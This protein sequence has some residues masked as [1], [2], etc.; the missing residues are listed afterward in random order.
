MEG[1]FEKSILLLQ[2]L[3]SVGKGRRA[4]GFKRLSKYDVVIAGGSVAGLTFAGEAAKRGLDVVVLEE[5][6]EIGKPEKCDGLV[7]LRG[8]RRYGY[9]PNP[10]VI[11]SSVKEGVIHAPSGALLEVNASS[12]EVVVLDRSAYDRQLAQRAL[13]WGAKLKLGV[14][15]RSVQE[16]VDGVKVESADAYEGKYFVDATGPA[17]SPP[18]GIIPA[19]KYEIQADWISEGRVEV[20]TDQLKYPGFFSWIIPYG[21]GRAKVG[22]AGRGINAFNA[23]DDFL[24]RWRYKVLRRVAA[25]IYVGGPARTFLS[26]RRLLVGESAGQVKPTT[27][28]GIMTSL[29]AA[30]LAARW[31]SDAITSKDPSVLDGYQADWEGRFGKELQTMRRLRRVFEMLSNKDLDALVGTLS[32]PKLVAKLSASDFDFH[33]TALLSAVGIVGLMRIARLVASSEAKQLLRGF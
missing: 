11:Q 21:A 23:L 15:A 13:D 28:G 32:N 6:D 30:V 7:S 18:E 25:P 1:T 3:I 8:L 14:R 26:G 22:A 12:L 9:A 5:H 27:A 24:S 33:A 16:S 31:V 20:F 19:A 29:A 2:W 17:S 4:N 10:E